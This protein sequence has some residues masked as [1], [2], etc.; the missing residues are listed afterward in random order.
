MVLRFSPRN[1]GSQSEEMI[2]I[3]SITDFKEMAQVEQ[4]LLGI[5]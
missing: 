1:R 2:K 4:Q 3:S 5:Q